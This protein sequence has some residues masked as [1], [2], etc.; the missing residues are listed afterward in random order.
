MYLLR[1]MEMES[2][3]NAEY[4]RK[5]VSVWPNTPKSMKEVLLK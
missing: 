2:F 4:Q 3:S 5:V 1:P